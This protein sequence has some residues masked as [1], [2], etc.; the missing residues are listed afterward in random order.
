MRCSTVSMSVVVALLFLAAPVEAARVSGSITYDGLGPG[1]VFADIVSVQAYHYDYATGTR[2]Y[3]SVDWE[4]WTYAVDGIGLSD[5]GYI[6]IEID[7]SQSS[8]W[9]A[10]DLFGIVAHRGHRSRERGRRRCFGP[11][12]APVPHPIRQRDLFRK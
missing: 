11:G 1:D 12:L 8:G 7:R 10:G 6:G 5:S 4:A 3:G 9:D 2:T